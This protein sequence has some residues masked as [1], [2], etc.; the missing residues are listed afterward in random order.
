MGFLQRPRLM[1]W[2]TKS[3][4]GGNHWVPIGCR[5]LLGS[6][7]DFF[8]ATCVRKQGMVCTAAF[9]KGDKGT[10]YIL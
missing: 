7:K 8:R 1:G 9:E 4:I 6:V 2:T 3:S 5:A 10:L